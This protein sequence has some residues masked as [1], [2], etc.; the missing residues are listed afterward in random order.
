LNPKIPPSLAG[1]KKPPPPPR[2]WRGYIAGYHRRLCHRRERVSQSPT[3]ADRGGCNYS[4]LLFDKKL[5]TS[6][7]SNM[8]TNNNNQEATKK[9]GKKMITRSLS[10][11]LDL[12]KEAQRKAGFAPISAIIRALLK[13]W[14]KGE[15]QISPEDT[16]D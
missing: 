12:W 11:E 2:Y 15:I 4:S 1:V 8:S 7:N 9:G 13:K 10:I 16:Q 6:Y 3:G 14:V 5:I